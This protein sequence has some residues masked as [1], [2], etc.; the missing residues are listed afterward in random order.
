M[1]LSEDVNIEKLASLTEGSNGSDIKAIA[2]EAG[3]FAVREERYSVGMDDFMNAI[4]KL[5][6]PAEKQNLSEGMFVWF[7]HIQ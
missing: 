5:K 3:M 6:A 2:M 7:E 4:K 1:K